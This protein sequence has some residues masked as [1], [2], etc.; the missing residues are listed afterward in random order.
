M[1]ESTLPPDGSAGA[2]SAAPRGDRNGLTPAQAARWRENPLHAYLGLDLEEQNDGYC[3][4]VLHTGP[5][6]RGGVGGSVHGGIMATLVDIATMTA[7][8]SVVDHRA[9]EMNGTAE[10]NISY[11]R[12]AL[13]AI[14]VAEGRVLKK[15]KTLVVVD[16]DCSDGKGRLFAKG[17]AQYALRQQAPRT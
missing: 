6:T 13:G 5:Q 17:R 7:V 2:G 9:E 10:L 3:R 8:A 16:V 14:V 12:P 4:V 11:L 1:T 15:G